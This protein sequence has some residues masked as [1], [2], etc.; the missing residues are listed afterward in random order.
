MLKRFLR[1]R[2]QDIEKASAFFLK[3]LKWRREALPNNFI[4]ESGIQNELAQKKAF[5][6]GY[7][8]IGKPIGVFISS[9]HYTNDLNE[10]K[11]K[12]TDYWF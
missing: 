10:Y 12:L 7:D 1:A 4:S 2:N 5:I 3:Y 8:K 11:H 6:Q 9:K